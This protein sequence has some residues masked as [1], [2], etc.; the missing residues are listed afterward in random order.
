MRR[1]GKKENLMNKTETE[2]PDRETVHMLLCRSFPLSVVATVLVAFMSALLAGVCLP[3]PAD[4][5]ME[6][7][8][9]IAMAVAG[10]VV[11]VLTV[12]FTV[13][14]WKKPGVRW[15]LW[16]S[17]FLNTAGTVSVTAAYTVFLGREPTLAQVLLPILLPLLYLGVQFLLILLRPAWVGEV[18]SIGLAVNLVLGLVCIVLWITA[19]APWLFGN[20]WFSLVISFMYSLSLLYALEEPGRWLLY[21]TGA[22]YAYLGLI[23]VVI[24]LILCLVGIGEGGD[25]DCDCGE[26]GECCDC[27]V[28]CGSSSGK[29]KGNSGT[30]P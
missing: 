17:L 11:M 27:P 2:P 29:P 26:C 1:A 25:C 30:A 15:F 13:I 12:P 7:D 22:S 5:G 9:P 18:L 3:V 21:A 19:G 4:Q 28:D 8:L 14:G 24:L 20:C 23:G 16:L 10:L 6:E